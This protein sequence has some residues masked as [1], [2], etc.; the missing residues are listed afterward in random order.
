MFCETLGLLNAPRKNRSYSSVILGNGADDSS[1]LEIIK[2]H[3]PIA[4]RRISHIIEPW[5]SFVTVTNIQWD[6]W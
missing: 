3:Y 5:V 2:V 4:L 1:F 6:S